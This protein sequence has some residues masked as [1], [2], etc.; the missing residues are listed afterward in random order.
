M[1][2]VRFGNATY[3][4]IKFALGFRDGSRPTKSCAECNGYLSVKGG[5]RNVRVM[6]CIHF[7]AFAHD[8]VGHLDVK[9]KVFRHAEGSTALQYGGWNGTEYL[10]RRDDLTASRK[11]S[12]S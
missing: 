7:E 1:N 5:S 2:E 6:A 12:E 3:E 9:T 4:A 10:V 8:V 11:A